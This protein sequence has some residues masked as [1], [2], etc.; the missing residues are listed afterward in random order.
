MTKTVSFPM[1]CHEESLIG[2]GVKSKYL[3]VDE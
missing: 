2:F 1:K 3:P